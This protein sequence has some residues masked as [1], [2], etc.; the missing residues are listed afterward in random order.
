[1]QRRK[2]RG[3]RKISEG[4]ERQAGKQT[5]LKKLT[6]WWANRTRRTDFTVFARSSLRKKI[7]KQTNNNN[8]KDTGK[9][10]V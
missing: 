8:N 1:V 3:G 7:K 9:S 2:K 5:T 4:M 10:F 6:Y